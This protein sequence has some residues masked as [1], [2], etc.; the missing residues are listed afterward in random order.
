VEAQSV[1]VVLEQAQWVK[2]S[3]AK[4]HHVSIYR[5]T[6]RRDTR[7][8]RASRMMLNFL[9]SG[10][11]QSAACLPALIKTTRQF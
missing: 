4:L 5:F 1:A 3:V 10:I 7:P 8:H 11:A 2:L 6:A 9:K